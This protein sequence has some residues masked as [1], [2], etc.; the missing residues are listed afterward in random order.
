MK[1]V[2]MELAPSLADDCMLGAQTPDIGYPGKADTAPGGFLEREPHCCGV[3]CSRFVHG[4]GALAIP[5]SLAKLT[6]ER[7]SIYCPSFWIALQHYRGKVSLGL[8]PDMAIELY[9]PS[10]VLETQS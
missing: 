10:F 1:I 4:T 9:Q 7:V 6:G 2:I 3:L 8:G 5:G